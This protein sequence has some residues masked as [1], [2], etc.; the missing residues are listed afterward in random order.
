MLLTLAK[1]LH[2]VLSLLIL[3][4]S[5][6]SCASAGAT[7]PLP[8]FEHLTI[9]NGLSQNSVFS[10]LK[11]RQGFMWFGTEDGLNR[12]DGYQY[13]HFRHDSQDANSLSDSNISVVYQDRH[14]TLWIG[15]NAGGLNR[16][17][18]KT[19][20]FTRFIH[21]PND[22]HSLS[23]NQVMSIAEDKNGKLWVGTGRGGLNRFDR[24][25]QNFAQLRHQPHLP[26]SLSDDHIR[27][28]FKDRKN[29]LWVGTQGGGLNLLDVDTRQFTHYRHQKGNPN[30]LSHD[31]VHS[32]CE[33]NQGNLWVATQDGLNRFDHN[34]QSFVSYKHDDTDPHSLGANNLRVITQD[35]R[36]GIWVGTQYGGLDHFTSQDSRFVHY[37]HQS[38]QRDSLSNNDIWALNHDEQDLLWVGTNSGGVNKLDLHRSR[39]GHI[40]HNPDDAGSLSNNNVR[41][42]YHDS[43]GALWIGTAEGGIDIDDGKSPKFERIRHDPTNPNSLSHNSV[44]SVQE[45]QGNIYWIGTF[46][47]GLNRYDRNTGEFTRFKHDKTDSSSLSDD[48][49]RAVFLDSKGLIWAATWGGGLNRLNRLDNR[50]PGF[51][52]FKHQKD[53]PHS[54]SGNLVRQI[55]EDRKGNLWI[56]TTSGLNRFDR[57]SGRFSRYLHNSQDDSSLSNNNILAIAQDRQGVLWIGN[58]GG[59]LHKYDAT[60]D[61]FTRYREK[62]GLSND[63]VYGIIEDRQGYLWL[64]TNLGLSRFS[65]T[66]ESFHNYDVNDGLQSNE[67]NVG[68]YLI[69]P[70]G[71]LFFGGINGFNRFFPKQI[72]PD[73]QPPKVVFTDLLLFNQSTFP[74]HGAIEQL[75]HLTLSYQQSLVS[76]EFAAL[77]YRNPM[78][79]R[80]RYK[81]HGLDNNWITASAKIR[82]AT[83]T[84][85]PPGNYTLQVIASNAQGYWNEQGTS[86]DIQVNPPLWRSWWAYLIYGIVL[87]TL[88]YAIFHYQFERINI[89]QEREKIDNERRVI[90]RLKQVDKLKDAFLANTSHELRTPLNGIIG[91]AESLLDG[92]AGQLTAKADKNLAM[93]VTSGKRLAH[94]VNDILDLSKLKHS[95]IVL[96]IYPLDLHSLCEVVLVLSEP[97]LVGK[98]LKLIN[99]VPAD[100]PTVAADEDRLLQIMHNLVGNAIKF[101]DRGSIT[102]EAQVCGDRVKVTVQDTGIG[103]S[104]DKFACLF[105]S[106]EQVQLDDQRAYGGTGLGLTITRQL[107]ELHGGNITVASMVGQGSTFAFDLPVS[108]EKPQNQQHKPQQQSV[109]MGSPPKVSWEVETIVEQTLESIELSSGQGR[110]RLLLVD[111]EPINLQVLNNHLLRHN[112]QLVEARDGLEALQLIEQNGPFDLVLLD[113]MMPKMSGYEVCKNIREQFSVSELPVIFLTAKNQVDDLV[114]GFFVG[115]NDHL[116]KP[117]DKHELLSRVATHLKL[118][119]INRN[120]ER[121]VCERTEQL[122]NKHQQMLATQQKLIL[123]EKLASLGTLMAGVAHEIKNPCNFVHISVHNL[124]TDLSECRQYIFDLAGKDAP[125]DIIAGF[126]RQFRPLFKHIDIIKDGAGRINTIV[127]DLKSSSYMVE[128][129]KSTV[130]ITDALLSTINLIKAKYK[131]SFEFKTDFKVTPL[132]SCYPAKLNQVF[133]NLLINACDALCEKKAEK[134]AKNN[135]VQGKVVIGCQMVGDKVHITISDNVCCMTEEVKAKLFEPF[136]TTKGIDKGTGL[137]LSISYDIVLKHGGELSVESELGVGSVFRVSLPATE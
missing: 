3:L 88:V 16:Y 31:K 7:E 24:Q 63:T 83:Y 117:I 56:A 111:D 78:K 106:F 134:K 109:S 129:D 12:F 33:D 82:Q 19:Q 30:S 44:W 95:S 55:F 53:N 85:L 36:G 23:D 96:D 17:D 46:G 5:F 70:A 75:N 130:C 102:M 121:K 120:L 47:G 74:L 92:V 57:I 101:T 20:R 59:G 104:E 89:R 114:H 137:G 93:V 52:H 107:V 43:K 65:P 14:G 73:K 26:G 2:F 9:E 54:I 118:L 132:I 15:T 112:Y 113:I 69:N 81:L 108:V 40:K 125:A 126:N 135:S 123:S 72:K 34:S 133:M 58:A 48:R 68:A 131:Q 127:K 45:A 64:S 1:P 22:P 99:G 38:S 61:S 87:V 39:F 67:F 42:L 41:T 103:I 94:L 13:K 25:L 51:E 6:Y 21:S 100:L 110:F 116:T 10:I 18:D 28:V 119:D 128:A 27:V 32:L 49:V 50:Q 76:L 136:F 124:E 84:H 90:D 86:I 115:A 4:H 8:R 79:N 60:T 91:L 37:T 11:D 29:Q 105:D 66:T 71:E 97:L 80:Y 98:G 77:D 35:P 62:D 122:E